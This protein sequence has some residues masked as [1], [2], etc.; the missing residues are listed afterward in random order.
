VLSASSLAAWFGPV[1]AGVG[2][3][4]NDMSRIKEKLSQWQTKR[5]LTSILV[6]GGSS[7]HHNGMI[8]K[9]I[10]LGQLSSP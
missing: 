3:W 1:M 2:R 9:L 10:S 5:Y 4:E 6:S 7:K 8:V